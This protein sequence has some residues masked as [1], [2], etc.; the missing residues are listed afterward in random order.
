MKNLLTKLGFQPKEGENNLW[1]KLYS[2]HNNCSITVD[3]NQQKINYAELIK[4]GNKTTQNFSQDENWVVLECVNRLLE[5]G[6]SPQNIILEK[7]YP[8]GHGHS[9]RLD[10][11]VNN[12]D[13]QEYLLIECK[14]YGKEFNKELSNTKKDGGQLFSYFK[15]E[16]KA[17]IIMLYASKLDNQEVIFQNEIIK[18]E[19]NYRT[20]SAKDFYERWNKITKDNGVFDDWVKPYDFVSKALTPEDLVEIREEDSSTIFNHFLEI[21]RHNVVSDKGNAFNKIFTLFLCKVY[22]EKS[23]K[24]G[25]ELK[26]QWLE[27]KDTDIDFQLRLTDLYKKGMKDFLEKEVTDFSDA[28]FDQQY[29]NLDDKTKKSLKQTF[30]KLRLEKNNEFAIKEVFD[31][32]SFRE[33][34]KIVKEVVEL[35]Q[36]YQIRYNKRQQ[37]LSDFFELLLT[38]GLKQESGQFFTPVPIAQFIIKSLPL[39]GLVNEKLGSGK[40]DELMPF[41][42]D[43][44]AGSGHFL[45]ES[46][47]EMQRLLDA[48][49]PDDYIQATAKKIRNWKDD[50]FDWAEKYVYGVEKDYRLVKVGKVGCYL[51]GDG[52][53][54]VLLSDGLANFNHPEYKDLLKNTDNNFPQEN[55]QFDVVISNPPYSVS[56]FKN[57]SKNYYGTD[58]FTLYNKLT[59]A[60]SEIECLF[61]ERTKQLLK[62]GGLAGVILPSSILSNAGIYTKTR[63]ILLKYFEIIAITELGSNTFMATP[64]NTVVLFLKRRNNYDNSNLQTSIAGFFANPK[65]ITLNRIE[66]SITKYLNYAWDGVD[67]EDYKTLLQKTPN[68]TIEQHELYQDYQTIKAKN[69]QEKW[70]KILE[71][72]QQKLFYFVLTYPQKIVLIKTGEKKAEKQFLGYE[73]SNRRGSEGIHPIQRD[74]TIDE[75]TQLFDPNI[76]DNPQKASTYIYQAFNGLTS[77]IDDALKNNISR[78]NLVDLMSF[79]RVDFEKT[80]SLSIKKKLKIESQWALKKIGEI[81][82]EHPKSK[83]KVG[84]AKDV[85]SGKYPF[86]TS[87]NSMLTFNDFLLD[88]ENIYLST[89]GNAIIKYFNG[90]AS[91]STDTFVIK[92]LNEKELKTKF[93]FHLLDSVIVSINQFYFKGLGLRHLQKPDF[94][95]IKIPIPPKE[96]QQKIINE[97]EDLEKKE[98]EATTSISNLQN[99]INDIVSEINTNNLIKLKQLMLIVRGASPRPIR[100]YQTNDKNGVNWI[101]IGDVKPNS[102][103]ITKTKEKITLDGAKK[104]RFVDIGDFILSNS[105]SFGRPYIMKITGFIHDGWLLMS[106]F[107]KELNKDY[108]YYIL[109]SNLVQEQFKNAASGGTTV[110]N[111][112][113]T[114]VENTDIPL[115]TLLEQQKIVAKI[116]KIEAKIN[117]LEAQTNAI[118]Q[119]KEAILKRYL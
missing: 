37:Y 50:H 40:K 100:Q 5:K 70:Q 10:I 87:G 1:H 38:T 7:T 98:D 56:S 3:F 27:G 99:N 69:S 86:F 119:Q 75:C 118:P 31:N 22:D 106:H 48:K 8:A 44:A 77:E 14:T 13:G 26:F 58:D 61:V 24:T 102:K 65:D 29:K 19:D 54:N 109:S 111:L 80:I 114:K 96:I 62:D 67:F 76:F 116:A 21:L 93:I 34:A 55:K 36:K 11:C 59:D 79:D 73:F 25:D 2:Q 57:A 112:N 33:N 89:G 43:Y 17:S 42:M 49:N 91:Y 66:N 64:S 53:A 28:E 60:S 68:K 47:H 45:T 52:L 35:L 90:R 30:A 84:A 107:S 83:I 82:Y 72:E 16:N 71:L 105:M 41:V 20:G 108:L 12:N 95:N 39:D 51:H 104:S 46:M 4:A 15:F 94:R 6:Y 117:K 9:A 81:I 74:K 92:S 113:I 85:A 78:V 88:N 23:T 63:E 103:Y 110:D 101:K 97:I 115:I 18:I 32:Q